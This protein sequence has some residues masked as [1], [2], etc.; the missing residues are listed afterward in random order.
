M[1]SKSADVR[2]FSI[3]EQLGLKLDGMMS[4]VEV[5]RKT[6]LSLSRLRLAVLLP[7]ELDRLRCYTLRRTSLVYAVVSG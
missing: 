3:Q 2:T 1:R 4:P 5:H 6:S 7:F